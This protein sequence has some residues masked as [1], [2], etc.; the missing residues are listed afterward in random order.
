MISYFDKCSP[1]IAE[2][3][4]QELGEDH[5]D[6]EEFQLDDAIEMQLQ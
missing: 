3:T 5:S 4:S 6:T 1:A 2:T